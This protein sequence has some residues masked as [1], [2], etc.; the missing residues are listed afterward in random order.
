MHYDTSELGS[1]DKMK[2]KHLFEST[3][4]L[5]VPV[6]KLFNWHENE[7][8]FERLTPP[9]DPVNV[10]RRVG[11]I[12]GGT[13]YIAMKAGPVPLTWV[14][15]HYGYKKNVQFLED[16]TS[17]PFVGPLPFWNGGW[18]HKHLFEKIDEDNSLVTDRIEYDFPMKPFG[19]LLGGRYTKKKLDQ[20]FAYRRNI[21]ENDLYALSKYSGK[22]LDIAVTGGSGLIGKELGPYLTTAGHSVENLVRKRPKKG[23]LCWNIRKQQISSLNGKDAVVHLAGENIGSL[24][25]WSKWKRKEILESRV[26]STAL[27]AKHLASLENPPKV[28]ICASAMGYYGSYG[29]DILT[30]DSKNGDDYFSY[31]VKEWEAAAQPAIDAGIR[32]VFLRFGI[33]MSPKGGALPR[34]LLPAKFGGNPPIGGGKQW[35]SWLTIDDAI[36]SIYHAI[37]TE[38]L[39]GAVNVASPNTIQQKDFAS[40]LGKIMWG[41][42]LGFMTNLIPLPAFVVKSIMGEMGDVLLLSSNRIDSSK[43]IDSGYK[44]RFENLENGL[45]H[46][47]GMKREEDLQCKT[48]VLS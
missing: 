4:K 15:Q 16:Q 8:A 31:V 34:M 18:H 44:F 47:L 46:I 33:I 39:S 23:E 2:G 25:R 27:V 9:F 21:T 28:L 40:T 10:T 19:F 36:G 5:N 17:G 20:M 7:G 24:V 30:E 14:T 43:L 35:W 37:T 41:P 6:E 22:P 13:V 48:G 1:M 42:R 3:L 45:R 29:D 26:K 32:V 38:S 12:D 11:G